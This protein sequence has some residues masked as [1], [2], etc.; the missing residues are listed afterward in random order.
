MTNRERLEKIILNNRS[1]EQPH[2]SIYMPTHRS[3]PDNLQDPIVLKNLLQDLEKS[4]IEQYPRRT[5][6]TTL[7]NLYELQK[8]VQSFWQYGKDGLAILA[9]DDEI[10]IFQLYYQPAPKVFLGENFHIISLLAYLETYDEVLVADLSKDRVKLYLANRYTN[11]PFESEAIKTSFPEL[12]DD[13]DSNASLNFGSYTG[14]ES[15]Y[16]GHRAKPEEVE[17]DREKYFRYL[18]TTFGE[19]YKLEK[20]P[21]LLAG[22]VENIAAFKNVA[23]ENVYLSAEVPKP[24]DS[25][26]QK[27]TQEALKEA[28]NPLLQKDREDLA[29]RLNKAIAG[30]LVLHKTHDI[31]K[32]AAEGRI[33]ELIVDLSKVIIQ[34]KTLDEAVLEAINTKAKISVL[35]K[36]LEGVETPYT[37]LLR[38]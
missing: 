20:R 22:T 37:A 32:A 14:N 4:L 1:N 17:K 13:F 34:D 27:A 12:F 38:Y 36:P 30:E 18:D 25:L 5:W 28:M 10:E 8:G 23:K 3:K 2:I 6:E 15:A 26:D 9:V 16:H 7:K 19:I 29:G 33:A 31:E 11:E 21:V 24:L 35:H